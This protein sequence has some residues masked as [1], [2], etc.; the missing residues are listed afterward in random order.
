VHDKNCSKKFCYFL[1]WNCQNTTIPLLFLWLHKYLTTFNL[2]WVIL[3][4]TLRRNEFRITKW[5]DDSNYLKDIIKFYSMYSIIN[6]EYENDLFIL[7]FIIVKH[8]N[9]HYIIKG[10]Q[11]EES[12]ISSTLGGVNM[13]S[14][15]IN[16]IMFH[17]QHH[18]TLTRKEI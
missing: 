15:N 10:N 8:I 1:Y 5:Y 3:N 11:N 14:D 18:I 12:T 2:N 7:L 17:S 13:F 9:F 4:I 6:N 16:E